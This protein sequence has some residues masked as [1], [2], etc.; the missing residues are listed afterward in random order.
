MILKLTDIQLNKLK[1][2]VKNNTETTSRMSLKMFNGNDF[3]H[4]SLLT[5]RQKKTKL[6]NTFNNNLQ[7][8]IKL[9]KV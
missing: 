8:D 3:T 6:G 4:E 2:A 7:T 1:T 9:S 5:T